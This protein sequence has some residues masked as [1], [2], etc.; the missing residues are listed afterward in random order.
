MYNHSLLALREMIRSKKLELSCSPKA[1][2]IERLC[3]PRA[4][5]AFRLRILH[6]R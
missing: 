4:C 2:R 6:A 1:D 5:P 3:E